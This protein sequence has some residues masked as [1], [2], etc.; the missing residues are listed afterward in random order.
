ME[1][2]ITID[3]LRRGEVEVTV[4]GL[5]GAGEVKCSRDVV[6]KPDKALA[7]ALAKDYDAVV[8][9]GGLK[10]SQLIGASDVVKTLLQKQEKNGK[11]IAAICAG[12]TALMSHGIFK[13]KKL[14]SYPAFEE[15]LAAGGYTYSQDRVV[16][17]GKL[18][19]SRGPGTAFEFGLAIVTA[20]NGKEKSDSL[21]APMLVK[22]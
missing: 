17:D 13:G 22:V 21:I 2:V 20:L 4:A 18:I 3:I 10:G 14:T 11:Y 15:K 12:P 16:T 19:T 5:A 1:A 9:P 8:I 7:D 6:I